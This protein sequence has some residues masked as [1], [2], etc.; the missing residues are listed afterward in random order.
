[1][2][3]GL[4]VARAGALQAVGMIVYAAILVLSA[5][6]RPPTSAISPA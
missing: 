2:A 4:M 5:R 1:V 3:A 6:R